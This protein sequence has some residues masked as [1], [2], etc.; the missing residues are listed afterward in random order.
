M[1]FLEGIPQFVLFIVTCRLFPRFVSAGVKA[2]CNRRN[3]D[4]NVLEQSVG[5]LQ[6]NI[7]YKICCTSLLLN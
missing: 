2:L 7:F 6:L 1:P 4:C 3:E 5:I